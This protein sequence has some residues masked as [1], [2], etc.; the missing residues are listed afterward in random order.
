MFSDTIFT[1]GTLRGTKKKA[2]IILFCMINTGFS[3]TLVIY[4]RWSHT[5]KRLADPKRIQICL[6]G[7]RALCNFSCSSFLTRFA[8]FLVWK[9]WRDSAPCLSLG[10]LWTQRWKRM[11]SDFCTLIP[12]AP[13]PTC[14]QGKGSVFSSSG[15][16]RSTYTSKWE[17]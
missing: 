2:P 16:S 8:S 6:N 12:S 17:T 10:G 9:C 14:Y 13:T 15:W 4:I 1:L 7:P 5:Q 11:L 3:W